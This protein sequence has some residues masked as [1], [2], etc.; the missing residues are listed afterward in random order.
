MERPFDSA[1][2]KLAGC[3]GNEKSGDL[4]QCDAGRGHKSAAVVE[5]NHGG[6][7]ETMRQPGEGDEAAALS[8]LGGG[9]AFDPDSAK[10]ADA[11]YLAFAT[12]RFKGTKITSS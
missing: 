7:Y 6:I 5:G 12:W 9:R 10:T 2:A 1:A 3:I 4:G 11:G 8:G